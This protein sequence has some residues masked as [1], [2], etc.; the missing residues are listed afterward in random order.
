MDDEGMFGSRTNASD[1][2]VNHGFFGVITH[3][4][5]FNKIRNGKYIRK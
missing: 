5:T 1:V 2:R 4:L 3:P